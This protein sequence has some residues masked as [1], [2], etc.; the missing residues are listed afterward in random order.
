MKKRLYFIWVLLLPLLMQA[1]TSSIA[2]EI[3]RHL[4]RAKTAFSVGEYQ[5]ALEE[6]Q[7]AQEL[8]PDFPDLYK[9]IGE[10]YEK[11]GGA[12]NLTEAISNFQN[13]LKLVPKAD[14][15]REITDKIYALEYLRDKLVTQKK[16]LADLS[17]TW[18]DE[19][20]EAVGRTIKNNGS[21]YNYR[22]MDCEFKISEIG[23]TGR[24]RVSSV[25]GN[26]FTNTNIGEMKVDF[27]P[28]K[29]N[30]FTLSFVDTYTPDASKYDKARTDARA[31]AELG[32]AIGGAVFGSNPLGNAITDY[33]TEKKINEINAAQMK[34]LPNVRAVCNLLLKYE[35]GKLV[36]ELYM[37]KKTPPMQVETYKK[38]TFVKL[39]SEDF[40]KKFK[41]VEQSE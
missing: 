2:D 12:S 16:I 5:D 15:S 37:I 32:K 9:A 22:N 23:R 26:I 31:G 11:L 40:D 27:V 18:I 33:R 14:D 38:V 7:K 21:S 36:G 8:I 28:D 24:F 34:D 20:F 30:S 6:Y 41:E 1:Q 39:Y 3:K 10:V 4:T 17:G 19:G 29:E 13:Y 25:I 35:E